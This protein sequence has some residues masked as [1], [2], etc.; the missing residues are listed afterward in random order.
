MRRF[1]VKGKVFNEIGPGVYPF[2]SASDISLYSDLRADEYLFPFKNEGFHQ[3]HWV[4]GAEEL[5]TLSLIFWWIHSNH[6]GSA[7]IVDPINHG[8]CNEGQVLRPFT[9]G[10]KMNILSLG[11]ILLTFLL[12]FFLAPIT[13]FLDTSSSKSGSILWI[14][15]LDFLSEIGPFFMGKPP[16][17]H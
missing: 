7:I 5:Y 4:T 15:K 16:L 10:A 2:K 12:L 11:R 14:Q 6:R 1:Q 3:I 17:R 13:R 9:N 8:V